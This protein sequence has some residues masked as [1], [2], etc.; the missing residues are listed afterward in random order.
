MASLGQA[1]SLGGVGAILVL[2][3]T[4]LGA[5]GAVLAII[6]FILVLVA[7]KYVADIFSNQTIF[8]NMIIAVVLSI[9]GIIALIAI[10]LS[11]FSSFIGFGNFSFMPGTAPPAGFFAFITSIII[12][13]AVAWIFFLIASI[14]LKRSYDTIGTRLNI[15]MFHTTGLLYLIG[16][17]TFILGVGILIII[18][19]EILQIVAFFSIPEQMAMGPQPMPGQ[20][21]T[22]PPSGTM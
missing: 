17:A 16:A 1:K 2:I 21:G 9:I 14:F 22:P 8:N 4:F 12:G 13:A 18:V 6:G 5:P 3:G 7:V 19:A 20:M 10:V 15:G 11:A